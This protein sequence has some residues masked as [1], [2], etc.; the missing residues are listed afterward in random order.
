MGERD[1]AR[2]SIESSRARMS[3]IADEL[4]RRTSSDYIGGRARE[5]AM[6]KASDARSNPRALGTIGAL[7]GGALGVALA[8]SQQRRSE[9]R[10]FDI[11]RY[12]ERGGGFRTEP[13]YVSR[14]YVARPA[15]T[16]GTYLGGPDYRAAPEVSNLGVESWRSSEAEVDWQSSRG[17]SGEEQQPGAKERL[18]E[19]GA[20]LKGKASELKERMSDKASQLKERVSERASS[21]GGSERLGELKSRASHL[22]ERIP[23]GGELK[24]RASH[25]RERMP[26]SDELRGRAEERPISVLLG[27]I[28][29]GA[30]AASLLP[31]TGRERQVMH[32]AK[33]RA[34]TGLSGLEDRLESRF[35]GGG[36]ER[37]GEQFQER[38]EQG[39]SARSE[40]S[41]SREG[42]LPYRQPDFA[43]VTSGENTTGGPDTLH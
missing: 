22:R 38:S 5:V 11:D 1:D 8:K 13:S 28:L 14:D 17:W 25:L 29:L 12:Y 9:T 4:S 35:T 7:A 33:E 10:I 42:D 18:Q 21:S 41:E 19:K 16:P 34:R 39:I 27:G 24:S 32:P 6:R 31:L 23:S 20:E 36:E 3:V 30:V 2:R 40:I 26:S 15:Y 37:E 43:E